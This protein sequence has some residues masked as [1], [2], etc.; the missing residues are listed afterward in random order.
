MLLPCFPGPVHV[1]P[2]LNREG[3]RLARDLRLETGQWFNVITDGHVL[4]T[5]DQA[6]NLPRAEAVQ[7][8]CTASQLV[9]APEKANNPMVHSQGRAAKGGY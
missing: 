2:Y 3:E 8:L 9:M 1:L 5:L 4:N 7:R 6:H